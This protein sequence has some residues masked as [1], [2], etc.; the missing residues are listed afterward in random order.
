M[1]KVRNIKLGVRIGQANKPPTNQK[2][3]K[4]NTGYYQFLDFG[5]LLPYNHFIAASASHLS[6]QFPIYNR[7][8][9]PI[10]TI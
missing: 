1:G 5:L 6:I 8:L 10:D 3:Q 7:P 2:M 9:P 4:V